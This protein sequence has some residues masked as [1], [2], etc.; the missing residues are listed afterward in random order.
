MYY[1]NRALYYSIV[2]LV[3]I[4]ISP[5]LERMFTVKDTAAEKKRSA[6]VSSAREKIA[7]PARYQHPLLF[8]EIAAESVFIADITGGDI[9]HEKNADATYPIASVTKIMTSLLFIEHVP[10][11]GWYR[12]PPEAKQTPPKLS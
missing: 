4:A 5:I 10:Q 2:L 11:D 8:P 3:T 7:V 12:V 9:W 1:T 6:M